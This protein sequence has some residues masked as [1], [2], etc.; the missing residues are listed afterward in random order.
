M[1]PQSADG[2]VVILAFVQQMDGTWLLAA[3]IPLSW[4]EIIAAVAHQREILVPTV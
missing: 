4:S 3:P 2:G 1:K